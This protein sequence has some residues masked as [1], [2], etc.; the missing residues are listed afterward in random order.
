ML[1][2]PSICTFLTLVGLLACSS[3]L[4]GPEHDAAGKGDIGSLRTLIEGG[5]NVNGK[6]EIGQTPL[7]HAKNKE[8]AELLIAHGAD[9]NARDNGRSTPLHYASDAEVVE[10]LL[11]CGAN[12]IGPQDTIC[13]QS[14]CSEVESPDSS[15]V[16]S[17]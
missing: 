15:P 6:D 1:S 12:V 2:R 10:L 7:H 8:V 13:D 3:A 17:S 9:V 14:F 11:S 4:S 16:A 5:A